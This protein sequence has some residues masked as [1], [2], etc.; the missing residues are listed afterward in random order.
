MIELALPLAINVFNLTPAILTDDINLF[1]VI[2]D[3]IVLLYLALSQL[4]L[5]CLNAFIVI[6]HKLTQLVYMLL[7]D[8]LEIHVHVLLLLKVYLFKLINL[9]HVYCLI[10]SLVFFKLFDFLLQFFNLFH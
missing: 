2:A 9:T 10:L 7:F 1:N 8:P 5:Q 6:I 3:D 4:I